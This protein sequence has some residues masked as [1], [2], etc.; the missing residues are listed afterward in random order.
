MTVT[1]E[2]GVDDH[3]FSYGDAGDLTAETVELLRI[4]IAHLL[5]TATVYNEEAVIR[6]LYDVHGAGFIPSL[7][8]VGVGTTGVA[9]IG[10]AQRVHVDPSFSCAG[11]AVGKALE[12]VRVSIYDESHLLCCGSVVGVNDVVPLGR[13]IAQIAVFVVLRRNDLGV[14]TRVALAEETL[15][16]VQIFCGIGVT[17]DL[18]LGFVGLILPG[19][20]LSAII[21]HPG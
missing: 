2:P 10:V 14:Q 1:D 5:Q 8:S 17:D 20:R 15:A 21:N 13:K 4:T 18:H 16:V 19:G 6:H 7:G 12:G 9:V 11:T 3:L